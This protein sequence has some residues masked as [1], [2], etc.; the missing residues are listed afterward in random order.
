MIYHLGTIEELAG[1]VASGWAAGEGQLRLA[2]LL[3][4]EEQ[5]LDLAALRDSL[6]APLMQT[7]PD[8]QEAVRNLKEVAPVF[9]AS[10]N[11]AQAVLLDLACMEG[12]KRLFALAAT[13]ES[14]FAYG[15]QDSHAHDAAGVFAALDC[16]YRMA[17]R[18]LLPRYRQTQ[19]AGRFELPAVFAPAASAAYSALGARTFLSIALRL[20]VQDKILFAGQRLPVVIDGELFGALGADWRLAAWRMISGAS[21]PIAVAVPSGMTKRIAPWDAFANQ[22][23]ELKNALCLEFRT[24][25]NGW[26]ATERSFESLFLSD[27]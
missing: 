15:F 23:W 26:I 21:G 22:D 1:V 8:L 19:M 24:L 10:A 18:C 17:V 3:A 7:M 16:E 9:L 6:M 13:G 5:S 11:P 4:D 2:I 20:L 14:G 25:E 27:Q 12:V